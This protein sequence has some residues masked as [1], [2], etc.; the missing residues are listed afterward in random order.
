MTGRRPRGRKAGRR[1][2]SGKGRAQ[3]RS[4]GA[5]ELGALRAELQARGAAA[6]PARWNANPEDVQRSVAQLVLALVEFVRQLLER[7]AL[8]RVEE[9]SL[10]PAETEAVGLALLRLDRAIRGMARRFGLRPQ[11]LNL[12]LGP[13]G[14]LT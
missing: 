2:A 3:V 6:G 7:Q 14:R 4:A 11:D 5:R 1:P 12:D 13:L 10:S 9:R 8:R